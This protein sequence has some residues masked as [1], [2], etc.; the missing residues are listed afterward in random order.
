MNHIKFQKKL[1]QDLVASFLGEIE[2]DSQIWGQARKWAS[3]HYPYF[4]KES[5]CLPLIAGKN[6]P[7]EKTPF[8]EKFPVLVKYLTQNYGSLTRINI[9]K[10]NVLS[11]YPKHIDQ[12]DYFLNK[13]RYAICLQSTYRLTVCDE[14]TK[15]VPGDVVWFDNKKPHEAVNVGTKERIA[16]VFDVPKENGCKS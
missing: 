5:P 13:D 16:V 6:A 8:Y 10:I 1:S 15:V 2:K 11:K 7:Y 9:Q 3:E 14:S 4:V 12:G